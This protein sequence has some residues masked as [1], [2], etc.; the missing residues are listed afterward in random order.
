MPYY[1][2]AY[3]IKLKRGDSLL[4]FFYKYRKRNKG[5]V[6]RLT[7]QF[8]PQGIMPEEYNFTPLLMPSAYNKV[9][10]KNI[11]SISLKFLLFF[12]GK[13]G[14]RNITVV[15]FT[16]GVVKMNRDENRKQGWTVSSSASDSSLKIG[17]K[18][19]EDETKI[20]YGKTRRR[21]SQTKKRRR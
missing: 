13:I 21:R 17:L 3:G 1:N 6:D 15:D 14:I 20:A 2:Q 11:T 10:S 8:D 19:K 9:P 16:C 18:L 12:F 5:L 4:Q 7:S